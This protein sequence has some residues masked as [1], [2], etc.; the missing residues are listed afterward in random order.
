MFRKAYLLILLFLWCSPSL[1]GPSLLAQPLNRPEASSH[2][3]L[4]YRGWGVFHYYLNSKYFDELGYFNLY[5]CAFNSTLNQDN[6]LWWVA[7]DLHTYAMT[8][9]L[10]PC[11]KDLFSEER[12]RSFEQ[13]LSF[14]VEHTQQPRWGEVLTDKGFNP[15]P[16]WGVLA[17]RL[18]EQAPLQGGFLR[19]AIFEIDRA[20]LLLSLI[21]IGV[22]EGW[23]CALWTALLLGA[24]FGTSGG[25]TGHYLQFLWL[26]LLIGSFL[27]WKR[28]RV[29]RS[30]FMVGIAA[31]LQAFPIIFAAPLLLHSFIHRPR[32]ALRASLSLGA[33]LCIAFLIGSQSTR[34]V[35]AWSEWREK[36]HLQSEYLAFEPFNI[37]FKNMVHGA[38]LQKAHFAESYETDNPFTLADI[39]SA[40]PFKTVVTAAQCLM[41]LIICA[42]IIRCRDPRLIFAMGLPLLFVLLNLSPYYYLCL[43]CLPLFVWDAKLLRKPAVVL[44]SLLFIAHVYFVFH[45]GYITFEVT[46]HAF[47]KIG[48]FFVLGIISYL[49]VKQP[50]CPA[51]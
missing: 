51:K 38:F 17:G 24:F 31:G 15:T 7:R 42:F 45:R 35:S 21:L 36:I 44:I 32:V 28:G 46:P 50:E 14:I 10:P 6:R 9:S 4:N 29:G 23:A 25:L 22:F 1:L 8:N 2:S 30:T 18:A 27:C 39:E 19:Q 34:G 13:D 20:S 49:V 16:M 12:K 40:R 26:P 33:A 41:A 5:P 43:S 48:I 3:N 47:S 37:G 11:P